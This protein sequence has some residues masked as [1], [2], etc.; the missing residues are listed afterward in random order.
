VR[1]RIALTLF[2]LAKHT[3]AAWAVYNKDSVKKEK[4]DSFEQFTC[5][6][7]LNL[8]THDILADK[9]CIYSTK[10]DILV[11]DFFYLNELRDVRRPQLYEKSSSRMFE[12]RLL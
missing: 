3:R 4:K 5:H 12:S 8:L 1:A 7:M 10:I 11:L 2:Q 6:I 9:L